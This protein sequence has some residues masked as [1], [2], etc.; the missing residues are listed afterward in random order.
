VSSTKAPVV[1]VVDADI[2][3]AI[4]EWLAAWPR[5]A[6]VVRLCRRPWEYATSAPLELVVAITDDSCKHRLVLKHLG[7]RHITEQVRRVKPWFVLDARREIEVYRQLLAPSGLGATLVGSRIDPA[8]DTCWLL[9]E[10]VEGLRLF[11]AGELDAWTATARWLGGLHARFASIDTSALRRSARL[12][13]CDREWYSVWIDR[14]LRFFAAEGP[15]R[16]R[17]DSNA[18]R[19]LAERYD[20]V[21]DYLLSLPSTVIHGEFYPSNVIMRSVE[22]GVQPCPIDWEMASI[23][24]GVLDLAALMAGEWRERDRRDM[25][26]A[27]IAGSGAQTT[28]DDLFEAAQ[29]AHIHL[30]VQWLG[31]FGRRRAPDI[32]ARDWLGDAIDRAEALCL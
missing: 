28:L 12:I 10:Y 26:A 25:T 21:I 20:R 9:L 14:A 24:P 31:W 4:D 17:H 32:Q 27:Y 11:E 13:E 15:P 23:G 29:Y 22:A 7:P 8:T 18:L 1:D 16:S 5:R 6:S 3:G 30:A 19:W 2:A